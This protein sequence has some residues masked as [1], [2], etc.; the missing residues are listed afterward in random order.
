M[1]PFHTDYTSSTNIKKIPII[2]NNRNRVTYLSELIG[3]LEKHGYKN[4]YI[5]DNNSTYPPLLQFYET[6]SYKVFRLKENV[7][8]LSLWKTGIIKQFQQNYYVYTDPD[9]IPVEGCPDNILE[10]FMEK[11]Q[12]YRN[13]EKVGFGLKIDDLPNHYIDKQKVIDW[14]SKF[15]KKEIEKDIFDAELDTT[16]ALYRPYTN[17]ALW[18]Q[19]AYRTGG[20]FVARHLPWYEDSTNESEETLFYKKEIKKGSSH[21]IEEKK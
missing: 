20:K 19:K 13:I 21:W 12:K 6:T 17:G 15:W 14:E 1:L 18:V 3:W 7:G 5:I 11:L 2:I 9:V 4:I 16:F 8:H 10:F